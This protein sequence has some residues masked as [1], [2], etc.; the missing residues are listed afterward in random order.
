MSESSKLEA[1]FPFP[2]AERF[3]FHPRSDAEAQETSA[4]LKIREAE[5]QTHRPETQRGSVESEG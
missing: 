3:V 4:R 1:T 2:C 5:I